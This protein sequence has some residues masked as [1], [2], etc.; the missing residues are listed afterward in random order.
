LYDLAV[1]YPMLPDI[2][3]TNK[4]LGRLWHGPGKILLDGLPI[5]SN[6]DFSQ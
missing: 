1:A 3:A 5:Q 2:V 6:E 4:V